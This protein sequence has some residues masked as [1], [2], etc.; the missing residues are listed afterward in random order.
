MG[1]WQGS[2]LPTLEEL[3]VAAQ[4]MTD[5][6]FKRWVLARAINSVAAERVQLEIRV[7]GPVMDSEELRAEYTVL[8]FG[9]PF[10]SVVRKS[11]GQRGTLTFQ[12]SPRYYWGFEKCS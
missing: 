7:G 11:D 3:R 1:P 2:E 5:E 4:G 12:H 9:A 10:C 8:G 6:E